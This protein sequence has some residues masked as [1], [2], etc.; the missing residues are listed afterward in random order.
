[1]FIN[2]VSANSTSF[3][4][5][6]TPNTTFYIGRD[7]EAGAV[8]T[9]Y[10][11]N[12]RIVKGT[13]VYTSN[14]TPSTSPLTN[15]ANTSLLLNFTNAGI[16]DQTAKNIIETQG[17]AK[18]TTSVYKYGTGS[19]AF[20]GTGDYL[21]F[22]KNPLI[23]FG[24]GDFTIEG[25]TYLVSKVSNFPCIFSNYNAFTNGNGSLGIFAGHN[26][27]NTS[28]YQLALNGTGFPS[29]QSSTSIA[30]NSWVHLAV[31]RYNGVI[32]LYVNGVA[33]GTVSFSGTLNGAGDN[34]TIGYSTDEASTTING[35]VDDFRIT[36]GYARYTSNFT[37][38]TAAFKD[39]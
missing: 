3:S 34:C 20:D 14:F 12:Y 19:I 38:P 1:M 26:S 10:L 9:G 33:D 22:R 36:R 29:I 17:D 31:V 32:T 30:Y 6:T 35:Y 4:N 23:Q 27:G 25:W 13:A 18:I 15:I 21:I 37:P 39:K 2:G 28:K 8:Y 5:G 11:S 24:T 7:E 16:F